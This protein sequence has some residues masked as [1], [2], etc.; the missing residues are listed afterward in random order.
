MRVLAGRAKG[1]KL[2]GPNASVTRPTTAR[3]KSAIFNMLSGGALDGAR[4]LDAYA[5]TGAVGIEGL[6]HG[7]Q[8]VDFVERD[9]RSCKAIVGNLREAGLDGQAHVYCSTVKKAVSYLKEPYD[10]VFM[11]PPYKEQGTIEIVRELFEAELIK[12][13]GIVLVE[14][15]SREMMP[16]T[17]GEAKLSR[18]RRYGDAAVSVYRKEPLE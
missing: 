18:S 15:S 14:H 10:V 8:W 11:D 13:E 16:E 1:S 2:K 4:V 7:A 3:V 6:S 5:G 17:V 9:R 12:E